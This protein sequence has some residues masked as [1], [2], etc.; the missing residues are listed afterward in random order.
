MTDIHDLCETVRDRYRFETLDLR[1]GEGFKGAAFVLRVSKD[2]W[3]EKKSELGRTG[4]INVSVSFLLVFF[5][6]GASGADLLIRRV[7]QTDPR[8]SCLFPA[9]RSRRTRSSSRRST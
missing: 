3:D 8:S 1:Q 4:A 6:T 9:D 7:C 5:V 2:E